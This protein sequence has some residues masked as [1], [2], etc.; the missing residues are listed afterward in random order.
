MVKRAQQG[1]VLISTLVALSILAAVV[2]MLSQQTGLLAYQGNAAQSASAAKYLAEAGLKHALLQVRKEKGNYAPSASGE[3]A[4][5]GTYNA[6]IFPLNGSPVTITATGK[7]PDGSTVQLARVYEVLCTAFIKTTLVT[8][9]DTKGMPTMILQGNPSSRVQDFL[10]VDNNSVNLAIS[11]MKFDLSSFSS[12]TTIASATLLLDVQQHDPAMEGGY[13]YANRVTRSFIDSRVNWFDAVSSKPSDQ[14]QTPGGD[15]S[16]VNQSAQVISPGIAT[17]SIDVSTMVK[18]WVKGT[19]AHHGLLL[20]TDKPSSAN[21][22]MLRF[23]SATPR[24]EVKSC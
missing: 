22:H 19:T 10:A 17:Y 23:K 18:D 9:Y 11:L 20:R 5:Q 3:L 14:W 2:Y 16:P 6:T 21:N 1:S 13:I 4:G 12:S 24:L 15:Y 8:A 7:T